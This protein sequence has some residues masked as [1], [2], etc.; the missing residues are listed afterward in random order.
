MTAEFVN[1]Y[2]YHTPPRSY[3]RG[4]TLMSL[5]PRGQWL[6]DRSYERHMRRQ[7]V[8]PT[9]PLVGEIGTFENFRYVFDEFTPYKPNPVKF[10]NIQPQDSFIMFVHPDGTGR[11]YERFRYIESPQIKQ[12]ELKCKPKLKQTQKLSKLA[13]KMVSMWCKPAKPTS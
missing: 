2:M 13:A 1:V 11:S 5:S 3:M 8:R 9:M 4:G 10:S 12:G 6:Y 7:G